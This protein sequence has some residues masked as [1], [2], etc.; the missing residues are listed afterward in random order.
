MIE[1]VRLGL[2]SVVLGGVFLVL[3]KAVL[4]PEAR[5]GPVM[6]GT[7]ITPLVF[8]AVVPLPGWQAVQSHPLAAPVAKRDENLSGR[9]YRYSQQGLP[10]EIE[11]RYLINTIAD[12]KSLSKSYA[13]PAGS[14]A[15]RQRQGV[16]FYSLWVDPQRTYLSA[17]INPYGG[18]TVTEAQF[19]RNRYLYDYR[20][21][22][23]LTR[24]LPWL[25]G[26][27]GIRD[28][29]CLWAHLSIP[30]SSASDDKAYRTLESVWF[31]WYQWWHPRFPKL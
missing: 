7:S 24:L 4:A 6:A 5:I 31:S 9:N 23:L 17:C 10:L 25:L 13:V 14:M 30:A 29:R 1:K 11:M 26:Q 15:M 20:S 18:S 2:L 22:A 16:G 3:G 8:P 28:V 19:E 12:V 27:G 21:D